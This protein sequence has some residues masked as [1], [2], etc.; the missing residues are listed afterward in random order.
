VRNSVLILAALFLVTIVFPPQQTASV[1]LTIVVK[2]H[3]NGLS[4]TEPQGQSVA[5]YNAYRSTTSTGPWEQINQK[6][7]AANSYSDQSVTSGTTYW[8]YVTAVGTNGAE[9]Q[10]SNVVSAKAL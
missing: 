7:I 4:W 8:Y 5:G 2:Q 1:T 6:L 9:S 10:P 3:Y